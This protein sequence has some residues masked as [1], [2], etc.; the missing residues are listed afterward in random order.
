MH[1]HHSHSGDFCQHASGTLEEMLEAAISAGHKVFCLTEHMPRLDSG[2]LYPEE[3]TSNTSVQDLAD[4]FDR[5]YHRAKE[6]QVAYKDRIQVVVGF[7]TESITPQYYDYVNQ[8][9]NKYDFDMIVGSVHHVHEVPIDYSREAFDKCIELNKSNPT[10][11]GVFSTYF[12]AQYDMLVQN[13]PEVVGHFDL[14]RLMAPP[15]Y[16]TKPLKDDADVWKK[17]VR[18]VRQAV[19]QGSL[20]EINSAAIRKGWET[21]YPARDVAEL[22]IEEGGKFCL[23][24]DSHTTQHVAQNYPK[25]FDYLRSL[26]VTEVSYVLPGGIIKATSL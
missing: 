14:I 20:F 26:G 7:E 8:L 15:E 23:S 25:C 9:K 24:D 6:A 11:E 18:N 19:N 17:V 1:S 16:Q 21:P 4:T 10:V 5:Y 3:V 2:H 12:D 22:I 13:K